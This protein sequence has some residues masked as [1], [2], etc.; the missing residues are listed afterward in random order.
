MSFHKVWVAVLS[1]ALLFTACG[2]SGVQSEDTGLPKEKEYTA[3]GAAGSD[4]F[5]AKSYAYGAVLEDAIREILGDT[6]VD[7]NY[8]TIESAFL[9]YYE[10]YKYIDDPD[11]V[12]RYT[13]SDGNMVLTLTATV[14]L[15]DLTTALG[16]YGLT[17]SGSSSTSSS[18]TGSSSSSS[19]LSSTFDSM[20]ED[21]DDSTSSSSSVS[22]DDVDV[23]SLSF[24]TFYD[25][26]EVDDDQEEYADIL[27]SELNSAL[28]A[29]GLETYDEE[30]Q[31]TLIEER[32]LMQEVY[33]GSVGLAQLLAEEVGAE[34]YAEITP[35]FSFS[36][37]KAHVMMTVKVYVRTTGV[38]ILESTKGGPQLAA[39]TGLAAAITASAD[40][41]VS[42]IMD[43]LEPAIA[44]YVDGGRAYFMRLMNVESYRDASG[45]STAVSAVDGVVSMKLDTYSADD[46]IADY[47]VKFD[48][49]PMDL[50]DSTMMYLMDKSGFEY[51]DLV[52][53][54]GNELIFTMD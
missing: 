28:A 42:K 39:Q 4:F 40:A 52:S 49:N 29:L 41:A 19:D 38:L 8:D 31:E 26:D 6:T 3:T 32:N 27:V 53:V 7:A 48:G 10:G 25:P 35:T 16:N 2:E 9:S 51:F 23:T 37:N 24:L 1:V 33:G 21:D 36:G 17:G 43:E 46:M 54:R 34:L 50:L 44:E 14:L 47:N 5:D 11:W 15:D 45:F 12:D 22:L 30:A 18:T 20:T 13:D